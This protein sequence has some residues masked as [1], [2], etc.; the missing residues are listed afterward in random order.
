MKELF[1][2]IT[3]R[4]VFA[5]HDKYARIIKHYIVQCPQLQQTPSQQQIGFHSL[6][7]YSIHHAKVGFEGIS[8][9]SGQLARLCNSSD[10]G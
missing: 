2:I 4:N 5:R 6:Q 7:L 9:S 10:V 8:Q 1:I 3:L